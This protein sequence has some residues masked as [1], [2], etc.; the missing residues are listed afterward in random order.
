M[1]PSRHT[2]A[3]IAAALALIALAGCSRSGQNATPPGADAGAV[4]N[5]VTLS[6][7]YQGQSIHVDLGSIATTSF[8]GEKLVK[9]S[10]VWTAAHIKAE[11]SSLEFEFVGADGFTPA[12]KGC[13]DLSGTMLE[14]GFIDPTSRNLAWDASFGSRRCYSVKN[15]AKMNA[16]APSGAP[17]PNASA[18]K[19]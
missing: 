3:L 15:V 11:R 8:N 7:A 16:Y 17:A 6:I 2:R 1:K 9:L 10:D 4:G 13:A 5:G 19:P 18:G 14:K 12:E